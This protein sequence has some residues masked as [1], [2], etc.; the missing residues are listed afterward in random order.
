MTKEDK[1]ALL[2]ML[3][4]L[5]AFIIGAA[6]VFY[7]L[8]VLFPPASFIFAGLVLMALG[9]YKPRKPKQKG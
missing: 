7:G 1:F 6:F 9:L 8:H 4:S 3:S 2:D 5:F